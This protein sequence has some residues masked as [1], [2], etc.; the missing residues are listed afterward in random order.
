MR[1]DCCRS[2]SLRILPKAGFGADPLR[3]YLSITART[4]VRRRSG[5]KLSSED[6]HR[7]ALLLIIF[8]D[9]VS[10]YQRH[11]LTD[12]AGNDVDPIQAP[13]VGRRSCRRL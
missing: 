11:R 4:V 10:L 9:Q 1:L 7:P 6:R 12:D 2:D 3:S 8:A 5:A 13:L